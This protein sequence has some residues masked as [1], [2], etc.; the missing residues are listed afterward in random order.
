VLD[1]LFA[2]RPGAHWAEQFAEHQVSADVIEKYDYPA[3][4]PQALVNKY[5]LDLEHPSHGAIKTLGFPIYMSESPAR[6]RHMAPCV[7]QHSEEILQE[8]LGYSESETEEAL[9]A[10]VEGQS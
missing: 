10:G 2:K 9:A 6:L 3:E 1:D 4:D 5:I 7:G 8:L